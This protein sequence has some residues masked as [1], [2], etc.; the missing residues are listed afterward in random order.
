MFGLSTNLK[1]KIFIF[2]LTEALSSR[3]SSKMFYT[4]LLFN[5]EAA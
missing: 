3:D 1:A 4:I 2:L 5:I